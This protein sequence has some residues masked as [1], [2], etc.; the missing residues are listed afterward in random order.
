M[1]ETESD[2]KELQKVEPGGVVEAEVAELTELERQVVFHETVKDAY[3]LDIERQEGLEPG[4]S[5]RSR[6]RRD[7]AG[8]RKTILSVG[9]PDD[10]KDFDDALAEGGYEHDMAGVTDRSVEKARERF[11]YLYKLAEKLG[12]PAPA[13]EAEVEQIAEA[14]KSAPFSELEAAAAE[15]NNEKEGEGNVEQTTS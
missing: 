10:L 4:H 6:V 8:G 13:T 1:A 3:M 12:L 5:V 15:V 2:G 9:R 14:A 11:P 7:A